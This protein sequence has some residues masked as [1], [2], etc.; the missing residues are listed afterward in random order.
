MTIDDRLTTLGAL[1]SVWRD[2]GTSLTD[3]QWQRP[4]RLGDW[5]VRSLYAHAG[6]WPFGLSHLV[7]TVRDVEP[8]Y[9][10]AAAL[11]RDFNR[12]DGIARRNRDRVAA[13]ARE[14]AATYSTAQM[15]ETFASVGPSAIATA[16]QLGPVV[17]DYF[18]LAA[19]RL[20]E[21]ISVG[22]VEATVHLLDLQRALG[23]PPDVPADGVAHTTDVLAQM[24]PPVDFI[25]VATGRSGAELFPLMV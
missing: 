7:G 25:E 11:L 19:L 18:G 24:A 17:V 21:V 20:D 23:L 8:T 13:G 3:E 16:R 12:P 15:I 1:W 9:P 4:T 6:S 5:D 14:D 2:Q 10:T 22:I